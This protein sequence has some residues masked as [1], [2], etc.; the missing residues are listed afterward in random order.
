VERIPLDEVSADATFRLRDPS[1]IPELAS[2]IG[3]LGQLEPVD[4]RPLPEGAA[5]GGRYQLLTGF[6]RVEAL[7]LLQRDAVLARVHSSLP[8]Q[9]AWAV[10]LAGPLFTEPWSAS[11]LDGIAGA[12]RQRFPW[13][14]PA[15]A[16]ARKRAQGG[17]G[18]PAGGEKPRAGAPPRGAKAPSPRLPSDPAGFAHA[19]ASRAYALNEDVAAAYEGWGAI[20]PEGRRLVLE[21]LRYLARIFPLLER[22]ST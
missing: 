17:K 6:R 15:W 2:A 21:Q 10:A 12:L 4:L 20:P 16:A 7:R 19:L 14:E 1:G 18:E 13:A 22:E 9:D 3:R 5:P 11:E 8:D